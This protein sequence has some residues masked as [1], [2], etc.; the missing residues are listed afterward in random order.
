MT[1]LH[2]RHAIRDIYLAEAD[3][4]AFR[5]VKSFEA[6]RAGQECKV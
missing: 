2:A 6:I 1:V 3:G 5:V 4:T